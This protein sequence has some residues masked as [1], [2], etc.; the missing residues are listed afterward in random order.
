MASASNVCLGA[1]DGYASSKE[2]RA[3][4]GGKI[5]MGRSRRLVALSDNS[6]VAMWKQDGSEAGEIR[7]GA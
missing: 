1:H 5:G 6:R 2:N 4:Q 7:S 3:C